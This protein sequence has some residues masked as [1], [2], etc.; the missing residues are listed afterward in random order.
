MIFFSFTVCLSFA[1]QAAFVYWPPFIHWVIEFIQVAQNQLM[2]S[3]ILLNECYHLE[4]CAAK[5]IASCDM[6]KLAILPCCFSISVSLPFFLLRSLP[7]YKIKKGTPEKSSLVEKYKIWIFGMYNQLIYT[8][9][10]QLSEYLGTK[11]LSSDNWDIQLP[12]VNKC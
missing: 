8:V 9:Q 11:G 3:Y 2:T 4:F 6:Q 5:M 1:S 7:K 10:P 12:E